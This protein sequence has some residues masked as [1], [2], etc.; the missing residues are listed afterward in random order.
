MNY[1]NYLFI[2]FLQIARHAEKIN[3]LNADAIV[4]VGDLVDDQVEDIGELVDPVAD[5]SATDG[6]YF[7]QGE[8]KQMCST[9]QVD[10][11]DAFNCHIHRHE[12]LDISSLDR[13]L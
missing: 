6:Q 10:V 13:K 1:C 2:C 12:E 8:G 5:F 3:E 11:I 7:A 4:M 9:K